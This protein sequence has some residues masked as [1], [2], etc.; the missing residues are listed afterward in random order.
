[1]RRKLRRIIDATPVP[2]KLDVEGLPIVSN[3]DIL[4]WEKTVVRTALVAGLGPNLE[5]EILEKMSAR[6]VESAGASNDSTYIVTLTTIPPP[7]TSAKF[8]R[9]APTS[10]F[11]ALRILLRDGRF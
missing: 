4:E 10:L 7:P 6:I 11:A 8:S 9:A 5:P 2:K 3:V 1:R